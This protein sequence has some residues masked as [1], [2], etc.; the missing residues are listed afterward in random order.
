MPVTALR[1]WRAVRSRPD[2]EGR[3]LIGIEAAQLTGYLPVELVRKD[4]HRGH[5]IGWRLLFLATCSR[6]VIRSAISP[7]CSRSKASPTC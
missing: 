6:A 2:A 1:P 3:A 5:E 4:F 7:A